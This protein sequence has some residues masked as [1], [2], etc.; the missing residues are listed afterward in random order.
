VRN[1]LLAVGVVSAALAF[2]QQAQAD[3]TLPFILS[4]AGISGSGSVSFTPDTIPGD[5][6]GANIITSITGT[7]SD[8]NVGVSDEKITGLVPTFPNPA[9]SLSPQA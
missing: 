4:G 6:A 1:R 9:T 8:S 2:G 5:P 7:F 3:A